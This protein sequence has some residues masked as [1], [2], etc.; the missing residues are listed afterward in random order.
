[1]VQRLN[2]P[3]AYKMRLLLKSGP[4]F[5]SALGG[6]ELPYVKNYTL[7]SKIRLCSGYPH[8]CEILA[9]VNRPVPRGA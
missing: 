4:I 5:R 7:K 9:E 1:M 8:E 2:Y 3:L 6:K